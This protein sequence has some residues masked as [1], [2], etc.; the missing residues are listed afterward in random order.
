MKE[1]PIAFAGPMVHALNARAKTRTRRVV[2]APSWATHPDVRLMNAEQNDPFPGRVCAVA[3]DNEWHPIPCP[4]GDVGDI[5]WVREQLTKLEG[6]VAYSYDKRPVVV[7]GESR[8]W[9]WKVN[10]LPSRY[11]PRWASRFFLRITSLHVEPL[12]RIDSREAVREGVAAFV[13]NDQETPRE[14]CD[15]EDTSNCFSDPRD[16]FASLWRSLHGRGAWDSDPLVWV[17]AFEPVTP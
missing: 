7:A 6:V 10:G 2:T 5:L 12:H 11:C 3:G 13:W 14:W 17:I 15:Y 9:P 1:R 16:S 8:R 4:I